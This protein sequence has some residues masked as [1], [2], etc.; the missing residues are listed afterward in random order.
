MLRSLTAEIT[1]IERAIDKLI[2]ASPIFCAKQDLL[3]HPR[4]RRC[5]ART[6]IAN[7]PNLHRRSP[8]DRR[9]SPP[10]PYSNARN[11]TS[12]PA[13]DPLAVVR[14]MPLRIQHSTPARFYQPSHPPTPRYLPHR[15]SH[16][17]HAHHTFTSHPTSPP[18]SLLPPPPPFTSLPPHTTYSSPLTPSQSLCGEVF[19]LAVSSLVL[20]KVCKH[21]VLTP[22]FE[23]K[24][25]S[26]DTISLDWRPTPWTLPATNAWGYSFA[27]RGDNRLAQHRQNLLGEPGISALPGG[28]APGGMRQG[29]LAR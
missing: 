27:E 29:E 8:Q 9:P 25:S 23:P 22:R 2:T 10:I 16:P 5:R 4:R 21:P 18:H 6:F 13:A 1:R 7:C 12:A 20:S 14:R 17:I 26:G 3:D 24:Q 19:L 11:A 15:T 28:R